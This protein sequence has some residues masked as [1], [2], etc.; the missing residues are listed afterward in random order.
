MAFG[1]ALYY[2]WRL[3]LVVLSSLPLAALIMHFLSQRLH[4]HINDQHTFLTEA[5][6]IANHSIVNISLIKCFNTQAYETSCYVSAISKAANPSLKQARINA[7]QSGLLT[8]SLM[9]TY[10]IG[11]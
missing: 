1:L 7:L 5:S 11:A 10:V 8:F 4:G 9:V 3:T 6:R 2:S